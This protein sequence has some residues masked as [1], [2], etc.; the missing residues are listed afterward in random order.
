VVSG[1]TLAFMGFTYYIIPLIF[2]KELKLKKLGKMA[3]LCFRRH[4][5]SY[6]WA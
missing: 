5:A 3:A 2:R 4:V 1:T 6:P